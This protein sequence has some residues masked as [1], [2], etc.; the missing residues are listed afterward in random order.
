MTHFKENKNIDNFIRLPNDATWLFIDV[1]GEDMKRVNQYH[2]YKMG[3][4]L[5][6]LSEITESAQVSHIAYDL[7][8]A[9]NWINWLLDDSF[10][11]LVVSRAAAVSLNSAI[12]RVIPENLSD[13]SSI[14]SE[15]K[16]S[17]SEWWGITNALKE[18]ETVFAA[19]LPT[20]DVYLVSQKGIYSTAD[21]IERAEKAIYESA[22]TNLPKEAIVDFNQAGRCLAF[23]LPTAAGFHIMRAVEEVLRSYWKLVL[24]QEDNAKPPVMAECI[25]QLRDKGEDS[26]IL[27]IIDHIR[28]LYRNPIM[29]PEIFLEMKEALGQFDIAKS[30]ISAMGERINELLTNS[31]PINLLS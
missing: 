24:N 29:H 31:L 22:R 11:S 19:E 3:S 18:F 9:R 28:D 5:H 6:P 26:K 7:Y 21:L 15:K 10:V 16:L 2:F 25:K 14:D 12:N 20:F 8:F 17:Y 23:R 13:I 4:V 30:A 27:D 1:D